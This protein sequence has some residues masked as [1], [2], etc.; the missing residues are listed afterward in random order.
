LLS[1]LHITQNDGKSALHSPS[2]AQGEDGS[3]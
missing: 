3:A 1:Q 2:K